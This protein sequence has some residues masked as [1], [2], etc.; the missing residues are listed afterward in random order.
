MAKIYVGNLPPHADQSLLHA[1]FDSFGQVTECDVLRD[2]TKVYAFVHMKD[3]SCAE[4]AVLALNGSE[5]M[6]THILVQHSTSKRRPYDRPE[7][8]G[9]FSRGGWSNNYSSDGNRGGRGGGPTDFKR[10]RTDYGGGDQY[11]GYGDYSYSGG[12]DNY[13][14][15]YGGY[16]Y[17]Q[18]YQNYY[19][20]DQGMDYNRMQHGGGNYRGR[21]YNN[22]G[23]QPRGNY[24]QRGGFRG[25]RGRYQQNNSINVEKKEEYDQPGQKSLLE[26]SNDALDF[27]DSQISDPTFQSGHTDIAYYFRAP[28]AF[29][30]GGATIQAHTMLDFIKTTFMREDGDFISPGMDTG[31]KS[32]NGAYNEFYSYT[33]GWIAMAALRMGRFDVATYAYQYLKTFLHP[34]LGGCTTKGPYVE[35]SDNVVDLLSTA[36]LG[37]TFLYFGDIECGRLCGELVKKFVEKKEEDKFYLRM[38]NDGELIKNYEADSADFYVIQADQPQQAFFMI[39]YPMAFCVKL[40]AATG[41]ETYRTCAEQIFHFCKT[42]HESIYAFSYSHKVAWG[43]ALLASCSVESQKYAESARKI[44]DYLVNLQSSRGGF[45]DSSED[46]ENFDQTAEIAVWLREIESELRFNQQQAAATAA[47]ATG[48]AAAG[49]NGNTDTGGTEG[50]TESEPAAPGTEGEPPAPGTE[51][52]PPAPG[53]EVDPPAPGTETLPAAAAEAAAE[54]AT[55]WPT[56]A[57]EGTTEAEATATEG[58]AETPAEQE[59]TEVGT[60]DAAILG[61]GGIEESVAEAA[62]ES[63]VQESEEVAEPME[64]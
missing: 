3:M 31:K 62:V 53:T 50:T 41:D 1:T 25:G 5:F 39:G 11:G 8:G 23:W 17:N 54:G 20:Q 46:L 61:E 55:T 40:Y 28:M 13:G 29:Y 57:T 43:S 64:S 56:P 6:G 51:T 26:A 42:C 27:L 19:R 52:E 45:L 47:A 7:G 34:T 58:D 15:G 22:R 44:A 24:G 4:K 10:R 35:G 12:Y 2:A 30:L 14:G 49:Q 33:N 32:I 37:L 60:S 16:D 18:Y 9:G 36:H 38:S 63:E 48:T 59:H 21:G